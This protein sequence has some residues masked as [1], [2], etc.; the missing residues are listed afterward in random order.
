MQPQ[1]VGLNR[2]AKHHLRQS[3]LDYLVHCHQEQIEQGITPDKVKFSS[4]YPVLRNASVCACVDL[5][6]WLTTPAGRKI[7]QRSWELCVVLDKAEYNLSYECLTSREMRKAL[8][9][10]LE[11]D[12]ILAEE[13]KARLGPRTEPLPPS[14]VGI[15]TN[16]DS[17]DP[18]SAEDNE[19]IEDDTGVSLPEV[20]DGVLRVCI[21]DKSGRWVAKAGIHANG[22]KGLTVGDAEEDI[23]AY[24]PHGELWVKGGVP[25]DDSGSEEDGPGSGDDYSDS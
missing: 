16:D 9:K 3:Q 15:N 4:S 2:V 11:H 14:D 1:D 19:E 24:N 20:V 12:T 13:I 23:W 22:E 7:I 8:R 6:D 21:Q 17:D 18:E 10:Y 25:D 5:Y